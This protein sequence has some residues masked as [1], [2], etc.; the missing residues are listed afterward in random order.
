MIEAINVN[1]SFGTEHILKEVSAQFEKGKVNLIIG[2]SGQGKSVLAKCMVGLH[3]VDNGQILYD[4]RDFTKMNRYERSEIRQEI[5]ML[6]QG[7][8]LF[9]SM[10]V[11][12]NVMFPLIM[13]TK[14]TKG[15]MQKRVDFCLERVNL[16]G[17]NKLFPSECSGGMQ[18]RIGI[19][20]AISMNPKYLYCDEPNSGL[21]PQT[22]ILIDELIKDITAE[23]QM[24]TI[25][26]THDM[27]S[28]IEIGDN[29][30]FIYKGQNWWQGNRESIITTDNPEIGNFVYASQFMKEIRTSMQEKRR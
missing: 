26:I 18:K 30:I 8:A 13:F 20:R 28:V 16:L 4:G 2:Q 17:K 25:V 23:Y 29:I 10:T 6:F 27:N 19:A 11:E 15:E 14:M 12:G 21:D 7:S 1:K 3:E 24:T 5:G 9:D 22:S